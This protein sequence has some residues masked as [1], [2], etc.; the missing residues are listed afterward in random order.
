MCHSELFFSSFSQKIENFRSGWF[1]KD[2]KGHE[3]NGI[4]S[5]NIQKSNIIIF[6][7]A[8]HKITQGV[9][10]NWIKLIFDNEIL[11]HYRFDLSNSFRVHKSSLLISSRLWH[12][13]YF[14]LNR[15]WAGLSMS[16]DSN[17]VCYCW[18]ILIKN[19]FRMTSTRCWQESSASERSCCAR[20]TICYQ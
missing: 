18:K 12:F 9:C 20:Q 1:W 19:E 6:S 2:T 3:S 11:E 5:I 10:V 16:S 8:K 4:I 7:N 14:F 17:R 13:E 15:M